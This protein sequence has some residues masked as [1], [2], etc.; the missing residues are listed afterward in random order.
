[1]A[2]DA[3]VQEVGGSVG[4]EGMGA[5]V[6]L[7]AA[8]DEVVPIF[9]GPTQAQSI[10]QARQGVPAERP[11]THDLLIEMVTELGG[12][13]DQIRIDDLADETF[14]AKIDAELYRDGERE[15]FVFDARL[16]DGIA[17]ALPVD[18]RIIITDDVI[19][20]AGQ[21]PGAFDPDASDIDPDREPDW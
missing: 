5:P 15:Q 10:E 2:H 12:T 14:Y 8:R 6:V 4:E 18:C 13:I 3:E 11:L 1:M 17:L 9:I 20:D 19:D 21:P 7:L 16:S